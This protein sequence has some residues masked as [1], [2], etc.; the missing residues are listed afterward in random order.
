MM[1]FSSEENIFTL[2]KKEDDGAAMILLI[3]ILSAAASLITIVIILSGLKALPPNLALRHVSIVLGTYA[4]SW[5]FVHTAFALHYAHVYY[6]EYEKT[7]EVPLLFASKPKPSY[8]DF[9]YFAI[10]IGMTCQTADVNITSSRI[11][12]L[13]MLQGLTAFIFN[14][15]L[16]ALAINLIAGVVAFA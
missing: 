7:K 8:L 1:F 12:L 6:Q 13:A 11:R 10:V 14:T 15:A 16:L 5:L 9:L 2:S 4:I 3:I